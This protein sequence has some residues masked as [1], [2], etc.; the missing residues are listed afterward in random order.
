[1]K[2]ALSILIMVFSITASFAIDNNSNF[3]TKH[4]NETRKQTI[5]SLY[6]F[7]KSYDRAILRAIIRPVVFEFESSSNNSNIQYM[8]DK[9]RELIGILS[10]LNPVTYNPEDMNPN[11]EMIVF[12]GAIELYNEQKL[13]PNNNY[14]NPAECIKG[15]ILGFFDIASLVEDYI[16][17]IRNGGSW[18]TVRG[19][20]W[21]TLKRY[22][23]WAAAAGIIYDI[24]TECF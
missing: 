15:V 24:V 4:N 7:F 16:A 5:I 1:M 19:L 12:A 17:L 6:N 20:L 13:H 21:R 10:S 8:V 9:N 2:K 3:F 22:G 11:D 14:A 18:S 23:G